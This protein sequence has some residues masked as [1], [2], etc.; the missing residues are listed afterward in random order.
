MRVMV[1]DD[2]QICL[3][4]TAMMLEEAGY[5]VVTVESPFGLSSALTREQ[6][7]VVLVDVTMPG[8]SGDKLVEITLRNRA[9]QRRPLIL[10]Y[11]DRSEHDL[12]DLAASCGAAGSIRKTSDAQV[13]T[14]ELQRYLRT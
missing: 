10:L 1:V 8:L 11:S 14:R 4:A 12:R 6:P 2:S 3:D 9:G 13:L 7:D 5:A